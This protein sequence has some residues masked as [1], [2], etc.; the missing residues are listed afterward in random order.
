MEIRRP[1]TVVYRNGTVQQRFVAFRR[2]A[3]RGPIHVTTVGDFPMKRGMMMSH[4]WRTCKRAGAVALIGFMV[5][6]LAVPETS[7]AATHMAPS[8]MDLFRPADGQGDSPTM[9]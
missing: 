3:S 7:L 5:A 2:C 4:L 8:A 9:P 6:V 1:V